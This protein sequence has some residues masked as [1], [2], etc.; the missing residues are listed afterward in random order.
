MSFETVPVP[1]LWSVPMKSE[2]WQQDPTV[3]IVRHLAYFHAQAHLGNLLT[4]E[5]PRICH[6]P[7]TDGRILSLS[8]LFLPDVKLAEV[9]CG[10]VGTSLPPKFLFLHTSV[11]LACSVLCSP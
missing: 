4:T 6:S 9:D 10:G 7:E 1:G 8:S 3:C 2:S 5:D 11:A